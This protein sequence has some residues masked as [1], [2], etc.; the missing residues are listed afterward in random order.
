MTLNKLAPWV[1]A[2]LALAGA[3]VAVMPARPV[4]GFDLEAFGRIPVLQGGRIKPVELPAGSAA[5]TT[6]YGP[7]GTLSAAREAVKAWVRQ[8]GKSASDAIW[9]EYVTDPAEEPD[10]DKWETRICQPL[11]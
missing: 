3:A 9:E 7:Y 11:L 5:V 10:P 6:H 8:N 1:A 2:G 4:K